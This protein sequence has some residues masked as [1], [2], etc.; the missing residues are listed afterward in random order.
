[1]IKFATENTR[2]YVWNM[3]KM[4]F[5]DTDEFMNLYFS[6]KYKDENTLIYFVGN[7]AV[8]SLQMLPYNITFYGE[9]IPFY[10]FAGLCT[11]PQFRKKGYMEALII[12]AFHVMQN[13]NISL[14]I[15]VPAEDWL[16]KFYNKYGYSQTFGDN[17]EAIPL[18][19][20]LDK[21]PSDIE[22]AYSEFESIFRHKDFCVQ[23][24]F[25]D[26]NTIVDEFELENYPPKYNLSGM[27]RI[28]DAQYL[29][30]IFTLKN[31]EKSFS[32][33]VN[34]HLIEKNNIHYISGTGNPSFNLD[35]RTLVQAL[36]GFNIKETNC[37]LSPL[38]EEHCP[39]MNLMLE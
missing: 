12:E 2:Q 19:K 29:L 35:I 9:E 39:T 6:R 5:E 37:E 3:W 23:K 24:S 32:I 11:L 36:F 25:D 26:F 16:F 22:A 33:K 28:I 20:I 21:Y 17:G 38:F 4:C 31:T 1:M 18:K 30:D 10:Y 8:A 34:D 7:E 15:L 14:S 13:R 27:S